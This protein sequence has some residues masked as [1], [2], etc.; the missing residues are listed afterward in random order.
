MC[1]SPPVAP[2]ENPVGA[3]LSTF[4]IIVGSMNSWPLCA[5][6]GE[7]GFNWRPTPGEA[8]VGEVTYCCG[9][10]RWGILGDGN[11]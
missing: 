3:M 7:M 6:F 1:T 8:I 9:A 11:G 2:C 5:T 10:M 4:E